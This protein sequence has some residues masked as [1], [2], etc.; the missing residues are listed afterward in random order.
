MNAYNEIKDFKKNADLV[1]ALMNSNAFSDDEKGQ[2]V[3][4]QHGYKYDDLGATAKG[5]YDREGAAGV[6]Y[7]YLLKNLAD[8]DGNGSVKKAEKEALLNS[9]NPYVTQLSDDMYYY[10]AGAKW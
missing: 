10:L 8:T 2:I 3:M 6:Y 5:T 7:F 1:P 9:D 4:A